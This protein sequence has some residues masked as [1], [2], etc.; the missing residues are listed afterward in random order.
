M[1]PAFSNRIMST[2]ESAIDA[3]AA[4]GVPLS[5]RSG[6]SGLDEVLKSHLH[7]GK[8]SQI[9]GESGVGKTQA[10]PFLFL[11]VSGLLYF[12]N[13]TIAVQLSPAFSNRIMSTSESAI[14]AL[15]ALE[16]PLSLRSGLSGLDELC[17]A[18]VAHFLR[19]TTFGVAWLDSNGS[20][21]AHRLRDFIQDLENSNDDAV[22]S[23][24]TICK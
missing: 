17:Y 1:S 10:S 18:L 13:L 3:L 6:L 20:F 15:V 9:V 2:S 23:F 8:V 14:D 11:L 21:R 16:V 12:D 24:K 22:V 4:L 7:Y 19:H 5:L